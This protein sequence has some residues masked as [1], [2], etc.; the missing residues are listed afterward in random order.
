MISL[1]LHVT[2]KSRRLR[3]EILYTGCS[4]NS[5]VYATLCTPVFFVYLSAFL[6]NLRYVPMR[7]RFNGYRYILVHFSAV[8]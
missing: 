6:L 3:S 1:S 4:Q 2:R 8:T 7:F 5:F